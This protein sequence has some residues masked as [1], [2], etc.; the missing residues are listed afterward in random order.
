MSFAREIKRYILRAGGVTKR[1]LIEKFGR[2]KAIEATLSYGR[3]TG[4]IVEKDGLL[5]FKPRLFNADRIYKAVRLLKSFAARDVALYTG[6]SVREICSTLRSLEK[7]GYIKRAGKKQEDK[8][9]VLWA[10]VKDDPERPPLIGGKTYVSNKPKNKAGNDSK[11]THS[12][13]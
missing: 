13:A 1:E 5:Y 9:A 7:A 8:R 10:L 12:Q 4:Q 3:K 11:D 2:Q 6:L